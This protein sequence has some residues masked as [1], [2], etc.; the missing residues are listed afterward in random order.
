MNK[1]DSCEDMLRMYFGL[2]PYNTGSNICMYDNWF[3]MSIQ[4]EYG[5]EEILKTKEELKEKYPEFIDN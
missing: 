3:Y 1:K 5:D 4:K 2:P